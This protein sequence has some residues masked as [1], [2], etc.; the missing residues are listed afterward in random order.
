[1]QAVSDKCWAEM[2]AACEDK[3][4]ETDKKGVQ[5]MINDILLHQAVANGQP[6]YLF[7][8]MDAEQATRELLLRFCNVSDEP[9][10]AKACK[11]VVDNEIDSHHLPELEKEI[12][13]G[14][15]LKEG[16]IMR[17]KEASKQIAVERVLSLIPEHRLIDIYI[18]IINKN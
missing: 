12:L 9:T 17:F 13:R 7:T 14:W 16:Q 10:V 15:G 1:M 6:F 3:N 8:G 18:K 4:E 2:V 11:W 5:E